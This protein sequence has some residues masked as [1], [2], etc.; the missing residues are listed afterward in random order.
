LRDELKT[1][2]NKRFKR[3]DQSSFGGG[4]QRGLVRFWSTN[5]LVNISKWATA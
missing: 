4:R 3:L 1:L 5:N 2:L